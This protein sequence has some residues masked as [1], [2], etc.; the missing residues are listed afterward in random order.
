MRRFKLKTKDGYPNDFYQAG[1]VYTEECKREDGVHTIGA[2][3]D[4]YPEDWEEI[5]EEET[6]S[7][8]AENQANK[9]T[10]LRKFRFIGSEGQA[11]SYV[12][13]GMHIPRRD[14]FYDEDATLGGEVSYTISYW[15]EKYPNEWEEVVDGNQIAGS[16]P[17]PFPDFPKT[18]T[19]TG[20]LSGFGG[21]S[22]NAFVDLGGGNFTVSFVP[23]EQVEQPNSFKSKLHTIMFDIEMMLN[24]KNQKYG[25]SALEPIRLFSSASP[26]EQLKVRIDDK[27]SRLK[28][29]HVEEDEDVLDDL[30]GYLI[31]LKIAKNA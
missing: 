30:I 10:N 11:E 7:A 3:A 28:T 13:G 25:N 16:K 4:E 1:E 5:F 23:E 12:W 17:D 2:L 22:L 21:Y 9:T 31:L 27:L 29:S 8:S 26:T 6:S 19:H 15:A 20:L 14:I 18:T 24:N